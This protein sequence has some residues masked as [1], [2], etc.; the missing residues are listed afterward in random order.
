M[1][2]NAKRPSTNE[3]A[4]DMDVITI[5]LG[6]L[7]SDSDRGLLQPCYLSNIRYLTP[8]TMPTLTP[9]L[10]PKEED[11]HNKASQMTE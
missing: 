1:E 4:T 5:N 9:S 7:E 2:C 10:V 8:T 3:V 6:Q 11:M